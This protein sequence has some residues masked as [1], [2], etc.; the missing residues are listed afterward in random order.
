MFYAQ[1]TT[2]DE[3]V[4]MRQHLIDEGEY[5]NGNAADID[6]QMV[7]LYTRLATDEQLARFDLLLEGCEIQESGFGDPDN[8]EVPT[9]LHISIY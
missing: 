1:P 4:E 5:C 8:N 7:D 6:Q 2:Y 3:A 9:D